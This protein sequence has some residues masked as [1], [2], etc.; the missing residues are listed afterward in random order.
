MNEFIQNIPAYP[1]DLQSFYGGMIVGV[2]LGILLY[3][4]WEEHG[5]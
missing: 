4:A 3:K 5:R 1:Q 2:I